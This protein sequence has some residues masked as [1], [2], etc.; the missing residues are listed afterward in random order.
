M[1]IAIISYH[2]AVYFV[3]N[4]VKKV[5]DSLKPHDLLKNTVVIITA[6]HG[7]Q[8]NDEHMGYWI[9]ASAYTLYQ[10]HISL[11]VYWSGKKPQIYLYFTTHYDIVP[12]LIMR[13]L[14][15]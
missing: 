4:E 6:D 10:L 3:N 14:G 8:L 2:N 1:L 13:V 12:A 5:L 9:H 11:L 7:E 15:C